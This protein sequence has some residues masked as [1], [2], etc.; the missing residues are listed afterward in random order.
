MYMDELKSKKEDF[1]AGNQSITI[2]AR[3]ANVFVG[4]DFSQQE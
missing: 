1:S 4:A 2:R 3:T